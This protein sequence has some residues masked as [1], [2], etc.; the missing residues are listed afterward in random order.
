MDSAYNAS[1]AG[2]LVEIWTT[3]SNACA[4]IFL[5]PMRATL[6]IHAKIRFRT[7]ELVSIHLSLETDCRNSLDSG[8]KR[9]LVSL[10]YTF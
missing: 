5:T 8:M 7:A 9:I 4:N 10:A 6:V 3:R 1:L 2:S